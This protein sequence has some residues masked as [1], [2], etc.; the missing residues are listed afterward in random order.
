[1]KDLIFI[2]QKET[3]EFN[4]RKTLMIIIKKNQISINTSKII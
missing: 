1:M 3:L 4:N 2:S